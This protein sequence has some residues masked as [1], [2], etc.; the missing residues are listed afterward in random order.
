MLLKKK[1]KN[2]KFNFCISLLVLVIFFL[3]AGLFFACVFLCFFLLF[4]SCLILVSLMPCWL[5][6]GHFEHNY[7]KRP[8]VK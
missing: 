3:V 8:S 4:V 5:V 2:S 6:E 7:S 1:L